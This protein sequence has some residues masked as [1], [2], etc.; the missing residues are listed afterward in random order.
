MNVHVL[1]FASIREDL[2]CSKLLVVL[3]NPARISDLIRKLGRE[4]GPNWLSVLGKESVKV[5]INKE[6][7]NSDESLVDGDEI[8]FLPPVTGG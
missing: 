5:A 6:I 4:Q 2:G 1:F 7:V 3:Q 8:A